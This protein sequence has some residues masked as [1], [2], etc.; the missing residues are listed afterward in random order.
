MARLS[1]SSAV[2]KVCAARLWQSMQSITRRSPLGT[3]LPAGKVV[4]TVSEP[5]AFRFCTQGIVVR[6]WIGGDVLDV[7]QVNAVNAGQM[8]ERIPS[9]Q[10]QHQHRLGLGVLLIVGKAGLDQQLFADK[11][12]RRVAALAG[13]PR[14]AQ[15][16]HRR[17]DR[18]GIADRK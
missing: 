9:A 2:T 1:A 6:L 17:R 14:R 7:A 13:V 8:R 15:A 4:K 3:P 11:P 18:R 16:R 12:G 5:S 10:V